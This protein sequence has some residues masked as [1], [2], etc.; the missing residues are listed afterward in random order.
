[1]YKYP[2]SNKAPQKEWERKHVKFASRANTRIIIRT[3]KRT[4]DDTYGGEVETWIELATVWAIKELLPKESLQTDLQRELYLDETEQSKE[5]VYFIIQY[6]EDINNS[7][8]I[9]EKGR[10][11]NIVGLQRTGENNNWLR[12]QCEYYGTAD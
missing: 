10:E 2:K 8:R 9:V 3:V 7:H 6:R 1:M 11:W 12:V 4:I 5:I